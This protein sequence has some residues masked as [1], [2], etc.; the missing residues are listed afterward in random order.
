[1]NFSTFGN[2]V[3]PFFNF[4]HLFG[5]SMKAQFPCFIGV[6][7][8]QESDF[9]VN[10]Q[11]LSDGELSNLCRHQ[12]DAFYK[13]LFLKSPTIEYSYIASNTRRELL[14]RVAL[15]FSRVMRFLPVAT[16]VFKS[17]LYLV[18][19]DSG[20]IWYRS[21]PPFTSDITLTSRQEVLPRISN[22]T[23]FNQ[24]VDRPSDFYL[25]SSR[26]SFL[27]LYGVYDRK[28]SCAAFPL[29]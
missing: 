3:D 15:G 1:M 29:T 8:T 5:S 10:P 6:I 19:I 21:Y 4:C 20:E 13:I 18:L 12:V 25:F 2:G 23:K 27:N 28:E 11:V 9:G 22:H 24:L 7:I 17:V 14:V 26:K 16:S